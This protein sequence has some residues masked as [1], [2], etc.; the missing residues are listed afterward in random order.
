LTSNSEPTNATHTHCHVRIL[1]FSPQKRNTVNKVYFKTD[2]SLSKFLQ[3]IEFQEHLAL[4][5]RKFEFSA[6]PKKR[7]LPR[8]PTVKLSKNAPSARTPARKQGGQV[9]KSMADKKIS[10]GISCQGH[11]F[12]RR[13]TFPKGSFG[14]GVPSDLTPEG[15]ERPWLVSGRKSPKARSA[16]SESPLD[17]TPKGTPHRSDETEGSKGGGPVIE[18]RGK[19]K[20]HANATS[21]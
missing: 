13:S 4:A 18:R 9:P 17:L 12:V 21:A 19:L 10:E 14:R 8:C 20:L 6:P 1:S 3:L 11:H 5:A 7:L 15:N 16:P 2:T